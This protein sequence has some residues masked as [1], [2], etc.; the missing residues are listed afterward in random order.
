M[1][2]SDATG[3]VDIDVHRMVK[4]KTFGCGDVAR[5]SRAHGCAGYLTTWWTVVFHRFLSRRASAASAGRTV[6]SCCGV[7]G[8]PRRGCHPGRYLR[9]HDRPGTIGV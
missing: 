5:D 4:V 1:G 2:P 7:G 6:S 9:L 8:L 3:T